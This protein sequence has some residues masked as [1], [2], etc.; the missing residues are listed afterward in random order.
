MRVTKDRILHIGKLAR[1][2]ITDDELPNYHKQVNAILEMVELL[3]AANT[4]KVLP[5]ENPLELEAQLRNDEIGE[6]VDREEILSAST[7]SNNGFFTVPKVI[8]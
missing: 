5:L 1:L 2:E 4:E 7:H 6:K 8:D 3:N